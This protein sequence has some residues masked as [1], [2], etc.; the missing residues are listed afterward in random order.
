M[1]KVVNY[2]GVLNQIPVLVLVNEQDE[3]E[4]YGMQAREDIPKL[5]ETI[6]KLEVYRDRYEAYCD[7]YK[8]GQYDIQMDNLNGE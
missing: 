3:D 4:W 1:A 7:G 2:F 8:Q 6:D 5:L